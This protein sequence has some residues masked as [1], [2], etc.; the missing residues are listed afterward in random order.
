MKTGYF[1]NKN[2]KDFN[3]RDKSM[4]HNERSPKITWDDLDLDIKILVRSW[5]LM[6][7]WSSF[8]MLNPFKL[9]QEVF[10]GLEFIFSKREIKL[11]LEHNVYLA[12]VSDWSARYLHAGLSDPGCGAFSVEVQISISYQ[13]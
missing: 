13:R 4:A 9:T 1:D 2:S 10:G 3:C 8:G 5:S 11:G 12:M 6:V 7:V